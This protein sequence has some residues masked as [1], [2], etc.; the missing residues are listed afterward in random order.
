MSDWREWSEF[1]LDRETVE[2]EAEQLAW[3]SREPSNAHP[4][5]HLAQLRR[6]QYKQEEGLGLLLEA[7][8]LDPAFADAHAALAEIYAVRAD[9]RAA[10]KH[11]LLAEV[12]GNA[13]AVEM[14][15]RHR[16]ARV[17]SDGAQG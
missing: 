14:L 13:R 3:I 17:G 6:M 2:T 16:I 5:F 4:Y 11:A 8:R 7:I 9:Y 12:H 1:A 10:W 15:N